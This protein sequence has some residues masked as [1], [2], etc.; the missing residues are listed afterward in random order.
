[1]TRCGI[2][3]R[4]ERQCLTALRRVPHLSESGSENLSRRNYTSG[5]AQYAETH[6]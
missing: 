3:L 5:R 6:F 2:L 4:Y 1:M